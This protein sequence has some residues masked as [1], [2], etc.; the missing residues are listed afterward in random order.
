MLLLIDSPYAAAYDPC[1][2]DGLKG[3]ATHHVRALL[4]LIKTQVVVRGFAYDL[5]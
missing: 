2:P 5:G 3:A 4:T 1:H